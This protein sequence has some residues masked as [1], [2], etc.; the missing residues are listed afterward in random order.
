MKVNEIKN[1][2]FGLD[3][4]QAQFA[5]KLKVSLSTVQSW[6][7]GINIPS[8]RAIFKMENLKCRKA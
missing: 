6:E 8:E 7:Q 2:R 5:I 1:V 4:T 3:L